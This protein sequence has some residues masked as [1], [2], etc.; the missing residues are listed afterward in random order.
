MVVAAL[1]G[2]AL[3][4]D[5]RGGGAGAKTSAFLSILLLAGG[6]ALLALAVPPAG[7]RAS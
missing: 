6:L 7:G 2:I 1:W 3:W 5:F 4:K